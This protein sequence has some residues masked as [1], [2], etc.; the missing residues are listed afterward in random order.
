MKSYCTYLCMSNVMWYL[1]SQVLHSLA[2]DPL[3]LFLLCK[4]PGREFGSIL[5]LRA[6][7]YSKNLCPISALFLFSLSLEICHCTPYTALLPYVLGHRSPTLL[8]GVIQLCLSHTGRC[9]GTSEGA[10]PS[11]HDTNIYDLQCIGS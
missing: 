3:H 11:F 1:L 2:T 8:L 9:K 10:P 7:L 6:R 5:C 4:H